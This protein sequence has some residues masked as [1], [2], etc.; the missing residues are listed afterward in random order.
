MQSGRVPFSLTPATVHRTDRPSTDTTSHRRCGRAGQRFSGEQDGGGHASKSRKAGSE[1]LKEED[2]AGGLVDD[3]TGLGRCFLSAAGAQT[4]LLGSWSPAVV[5]WFTSRT[6]AFG[7]RSP[8]APLRV[9]VGRDKGGAC[10]VYFFRNFPL[11]LGD[12]T[13]LPTNA[14][15]TEGQ[16]SELCSVSP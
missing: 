1:G 16:R 4:P 9:S 8:A 11:F 15:G 7:V 2:W 12:C 10:T 6:S 5:S 14:L 13:T 3:G